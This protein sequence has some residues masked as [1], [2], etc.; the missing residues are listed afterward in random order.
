MATHATYEQL[1]ERW[2]TADGKE[3]LAKVI[4]AA[5]KQENWAPILKGFPCV[6][7][8]ENGRDLRFVELP[9]AK[10][11]EADL[12]EANL[13]EADIRWADLRDADLRDA[14]LRGADLVQACL[15]SST[16]TGA[17]LYGT[18]RDDWSIKGVKCDYVF[19][20]REAEERSPSS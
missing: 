10:L 20:D 13:I 1:R 4:A 16:L 11:R 14:D 3:R 19:W 8:V 7:E 17:K 2:K 12:I 5:K 15:D 18:A 9:G 6:E